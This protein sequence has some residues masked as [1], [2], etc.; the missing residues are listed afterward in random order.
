VHTAYGGRRLVA[1]CKLGG[2]PP[3]ANFVSE[4]IPKLQSM[5]ILAVDMNMRKLSCEVLALVLN[6]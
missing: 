1:K 5:F 3:G 2:L 6:K 4:F